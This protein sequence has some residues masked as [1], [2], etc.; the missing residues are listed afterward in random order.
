MTG[1]CLQALRAAEVAGLEFDRRAYADALE[2]LKRVT[3]ADGTVGYTSAGDACPPV[4]GVNEA[5][6]AHP[7]MT[8]VGLLSRMYIEKT[9]DAPWMRSAARKILQDPPAWDERRRSV[10]SYYWYYGALALSTYDTPDRTEWETFRDS[11]GRALRSSQVRD[12]EKCGAGSWDP[13]AD[14]WG[15]IGSRIYTTAMN[16]LALE[17]ILDYSSL[18]PL[19]NL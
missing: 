13:E 7:T 8:A 15:A 18:R 6:E 14:R 2:W 3:S 9:R 10:D 19:R 1:W 12:E 11:L 4:Q 17:V 16:I 5:W